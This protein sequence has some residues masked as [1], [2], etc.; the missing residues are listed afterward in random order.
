MALRPG[1]LLTL[2]RQPMLCD[3]NADVA[4]VAY[5]VREG[6]VMA[7]RPGNLLTL[8]RQ[9]MLCDQDAD[10]AIMAYLVRGFEEGVD[11]TNGPGQEDEY[12]DEPHQ[13]ARC[14]PRLSARVHCLV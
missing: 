8:H 4:I 2:H 10:V 3:Q 11:D 9:P 6:G 14:R 1:N 7:L 13:R 12:G 5:L